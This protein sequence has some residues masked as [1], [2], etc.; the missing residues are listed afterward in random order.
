MDG[1]RHAY[2]HTKREVAS[3]V[4]GRRHTVHQGI[5]IAALEMVRR[6]APISEIGSGSPIRP[7]SDQTIP[8]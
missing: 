3:G 8:C 5:D 6:G 1:V 7:E 4:R 2:T